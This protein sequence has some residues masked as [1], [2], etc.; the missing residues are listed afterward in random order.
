MPF[1]DREERQ[2][3]QRRY[4]PE[5]YERNK[6]HLRAQTKE[7]KRRI[8]AWY[9]AFKETCKCSE[10][11]ESHPAALEFHHIDGKGV[12]DKSLRKYAAISTLVSAGRSPKIIANE[13]MKCQ[14][15]CA[16]CHRKHHWQHHKKTKEEIRQEI[17]DAY[18][19]RIT[20]VD[21]TSAYA[22]PE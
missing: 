14:V 7:R 8:K 4:A 22:P 3:Y 11:D 17:K 5:Y 6:A 12:F 19:H 1:K 20:D 10:C 15:L 9:V 18:K 13:L 21:I 16:N 2:R